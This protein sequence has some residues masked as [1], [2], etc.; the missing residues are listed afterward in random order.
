MADFEAIWTGLFP[1]VHSVP[2]ERFCAHLP[3]AV[4]PLGDYKSEERRVMIR[5]MVEFFLG[6]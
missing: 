4:G 6:E 1:G 3:D 2:L 5:K